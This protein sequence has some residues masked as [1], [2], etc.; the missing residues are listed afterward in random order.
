M[1]ARSGDGRAIVHFAAASGSDVYMDWLLF[2]AE[3]KTAQNW[4]MLGEKAQDGSSVLHALARADASTKDR[5][6]AI[7]ALA[8][9]IFRS[10]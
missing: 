2:S 7:N 3:T 6:Y 8:K 9:K 1:T 10:V 4:L 5:Q